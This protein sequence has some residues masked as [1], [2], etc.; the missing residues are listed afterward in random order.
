MKKTMSERYTTESLVCWING[1]IMG[2]EQAIGMYPGGQKPA[3]DTLNT[4][5]AI[6]R[7]IKNKLKA[8]DALC[9][10]AKMG[11]LYMD[12]AGPLFSDHICGDPNSSCDASCEESAQWARD[13]EIFRKAIADYEEEK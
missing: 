13:R 7:A 2:C 5:V 9:A 10:A 12:H 6:Y 3:E 8:A 1:E 11:L 4:E